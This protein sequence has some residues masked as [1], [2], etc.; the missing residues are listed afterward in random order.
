MP[1]RQGEIEFKRKRRQIKKETV[2]GGVW[3]KAFGKSTEKNLKLFGS[4]TRRKES[5]GAFSQLERGE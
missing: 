3:E 5:Q 4:G 2:K 1:E